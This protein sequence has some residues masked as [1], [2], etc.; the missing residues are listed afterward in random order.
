[1]SLCKKKQISLIIEDVIKPVWK[2]FL[3]DLV[4][5]A[6]RQDCSVRVSIA[7]TD[8]CKGTFISYTSYRSQLS[9]PQGKWTPFPTNEILSTIRCKNGEY[10]QT[11]L[12][13]RDYIFCPDRPHL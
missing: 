13:T 12:S 2:I 5:F 9:S 11:P 1:L 4:D 10:K 6:Q 8:K 7:N 3:R